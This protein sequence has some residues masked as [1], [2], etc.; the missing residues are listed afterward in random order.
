MQWRNLAE[1]LCR[2]ASS[3]KNVDR[4]AMWLGGTVSALAAAVAVVVVI[5][6]IRR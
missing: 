4:V 6:L 2:F 1:W 5:M 3:Q